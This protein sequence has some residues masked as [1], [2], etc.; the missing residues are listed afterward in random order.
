MS[1]K[2]LSWFYNLVALVT[3]PLQP[4]V[5]KGQEIKKLLFWAL[6]FKSKQEPVLMAKIVSKIQ[7]GLHS[8]HLGNQMK[9]AAGKET[10]I[11]FS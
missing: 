2:S 4:Q 9:I 1:F 3:F 8:N 7:I 10:S 5:L 11:S 6:L